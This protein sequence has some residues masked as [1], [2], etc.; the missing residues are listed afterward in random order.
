VA[1]SPKSEGST[2]RLFPVTARQR[3][4]VAVTAG[5]LGVGVMSTP[6]GS[7]HAWADIKH[8]RHQHSQA[9]HSVRHARADLDESSKETR[10]AYVA[11]SRSKA[12]LRAARH[13]FQVARAHVQAA[14]DRLTRIRHQLD[15]AKAR[16]DRARTNLERERR[17]V[18]RQRERLVHTVTSFYEDGDPQLM[19]FISLLGSSTPDDLTSKQA[20]N[21]LV[22]DS[23]DQILDSLRASQVLLQVQTDERAKAAAQVARKKA[24]A[25]ANLELKRRYKA[26]ALEAK[27]RVA[28]NVRAKKHAWA[29]ARKARAHDKALLARAKRHDARIQRLIQAAI[30]REQRRGGGYHGDTGGLLMRPVNGPITSPYGWRIHPIYHYWGLHDGDD[31]GAPCG[32]P[33][34]AV[35]NG[36]VMSEYYSSIWGN[37][38]YLNLGQINGNNVTV[39]YNHLS[40]YRSHVGQRVTRGQVVGLVGTTGWSTGCHT[41]FTVLVNGRA[42]N[43]TPWFG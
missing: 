18:A 23:Q 40:A 28:K 42:V 26:Q 2:V 15:L 4:V 36:T 24:Q 3:L 17:S 32:A 1:A 33:L 14:R 5:A 6:L 22:L 19:G 29:L 25:A 13:D 16:L 39:I 21:S 41:H 7:S 43:P 20:N 37:R 11:L 9:Q 10:H 12:D 27:K 34:F 8:L 30:A 38:L 31:F 35:A